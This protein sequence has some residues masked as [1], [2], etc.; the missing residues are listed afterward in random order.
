M[1]RK[2]LWLTFWV[3]MT[4]WLG[5]AWGCAARTRVQ[6][7][8]WAG[9]GPAVDVPTVA[10]NQPTSLGPAAEGAVPR[11]GP[12]ATAGPEGGMAAADLP[13]QD[14]WPEMVI[15]PASGVTRH[16]PVYFQDWEW[17]RPE[18]GASSQLMAEQLTAA[19]EAAQADGAA[20]RA[21]DAVVQAGK[22]ALDLGT[23]P[24][25]ILIEPPWTRE[26]TP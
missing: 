15:G 26:V 12:T 2:V 3:T 16:W 13:R 19:M 17:R 21:A 7:G 10:E 9:R 18:A 25:K 22:F 4:F 14:L 24:L 5:H 1:R 11:S 6:E 8:R 20:D 23:L